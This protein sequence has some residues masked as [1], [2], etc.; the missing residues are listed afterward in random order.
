MMRKLLLYLIGLTFTSLVAT[1]ARD[2]VGRE[3]AWDQLPLLYAIM[4]G[5]FI[6]TLAVVRLQSRS[7]GSAKNTGERLSA[8]HPRRRSAPD[9]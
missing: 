5:S 2:A 6:L 7:H 1:A 9:P 4:F 3:Q 8:F